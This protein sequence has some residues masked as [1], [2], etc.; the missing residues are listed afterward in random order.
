MFWRFPKGSRKQRVHTTEAKS[1][2][3][4][5]A[6]RALDIVLASVLL[7][8]FSPI[9]LAAAALV[10]VSSRGPILFRQQR[11][12]Q[13]G[14]LFWFYKFR[15]MYVNAV[16]AG[17]DQSKASG[18]L[19]KLKVDPR[20]TPIGKWLRRF[21]IDELPQLLNVLKGDMSMVGPRPLVPFML[22]P[23]PE[24]AAERAKVRPGITGLWQIRARHENTSAAF[25]QSH[26]LEYVRDQ[27]LAT[28]L[29]ILLAT[30]P[31]VLSGKGAV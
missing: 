20:V 11:V 19:V 24:F 23:Y 26:D 27:S 8:L 5:V 10:F 21:S 14:R 18:I 9:L 4:P 6:K 31:Q 7:V 15:T 1:C 30:A 3:V 25:M 28:D 2:A 29:K 22:T 12:G 17:E 16:A 13:G